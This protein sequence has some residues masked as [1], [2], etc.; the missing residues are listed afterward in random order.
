MEFYLIVNKD[1]NVKIVS[2]CVELEE[3]LYLVR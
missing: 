1:E 3:K 2:K